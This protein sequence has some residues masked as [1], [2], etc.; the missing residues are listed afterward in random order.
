[1]FFTV[2]IDSVS[3]GLRGSED[4][5]AESVARPTATRAPNLIKSRSSDTA[6][7]FVQVFRHPK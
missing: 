5:Q 4:A 2:P 3:I 1:M 7:F 6:R